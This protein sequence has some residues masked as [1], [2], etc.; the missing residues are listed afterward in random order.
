MENEHQNEISRLDKFRYSLIN[1]KNE[2]KTNPYGNVPI[3][4]KDIDDLADEILKY[5]K[6]Y[7]EFLPF[8]FMME[9]LAKLGHCPNLLND[10]NGNWAISGDGF[11]NVV[12]GDKPSD[13]DTHFF[14]QAGLWRNTP[15]EALL[16]YLNDEEDEKDTNL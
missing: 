3:T 9:Q 12:I 11:Q 14:V 5:I 2:D 1:R 16:C 13:V 7:F 4:D 8:D 15:R 6:L 10:D